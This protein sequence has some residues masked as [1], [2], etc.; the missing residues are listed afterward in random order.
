M[1]KVII[2]TV[3]LVLGILF[4]AC[5]KEQAE[6]YDVVIC[7]GGLSSGIDV[8]GYK[9]VSFRKEEYHRSDAEKTTIETILNK[10]C[11]FRYLHSVSSITGNYEVYHNDE[12]N[13]QIK[14]SAG[15]KI[16]GII[17]K[18]LDGTIMLAGETIQ[19]SDEYFL[20]LKNVIGKVFCTD[21]DDYVL[22]C[23]TRYTD[24]SSEDSFI[25][26][27]EAPGRTV[28]YYDV[29]Y[30]K[31]FGKY[32]GDVIRGIIHANGDIHTIVHHEVSDSKFEN[33]TIDENVLNETIETVVL[34]IVAPNYSVEHYE[35]DSMYWKLLDGKPF[36]ICGIALQCISPIGFETNSL[37]LLAIDPNTL[38][39]K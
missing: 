29:E 33:I 18:D 13:V 8:S 38:I 32:R 23:K 36:L 11:V 28:Q 30:V 21:L 14:Y 3:V 15:G 24:L 26:Q 37:V 34:E 6:L 10:D 7:D 2:V 1:K 4:S 19:N 35:V 22:T 17:S 16:S 27:A 12:L 5:Q 20:W 9:W 25:P 31:Y 39:H